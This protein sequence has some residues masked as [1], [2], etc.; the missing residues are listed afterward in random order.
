M[1][2]RPDFA[3]LAG[4]SQEIGRRIALGVDELVEFARAAAGE[5]SLT[6]K[7]VHLGDVVDDSLADARLY[8]QDGVVY[9]EAPDRA[10]LGTPLDRE[11]FR[12]VVRNLV[13]Y[14]LEYGRPP[15]RVLVSV[16]DVD[17]QVRIED[18]SP[19]MSPEERGAALE[20]PASGPSLEAAFGT[21]LG[22]FVCRPIIEAHG[23]TLEAGEG[24]GGITTFTVRVPRELGGA[25]AT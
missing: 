8:R 9:R 1:L 22:L 21:G 19:G 25:A 24:P 15:V 5:I 13:R 3:T 23:G 18:A 6:R 20:R 12:L 16:D 14:M 11:R 10:D 7:W 4:E 17:F 2:G